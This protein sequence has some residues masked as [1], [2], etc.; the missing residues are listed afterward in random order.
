MGKT[1]LIQ[2]ELIFTL[3]LRTNEGAKLNAMWALCTFL[4]C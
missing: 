1:F 3:F 2:I 4:T